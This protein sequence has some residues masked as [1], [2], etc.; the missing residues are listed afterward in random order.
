MRA[1]IAVPTIVCLA[2]NVS[3]SSTGHL[4]GH[5]VLLRADDVLRRPYAAILQNADNTSP[6]ASAPVLTRRVTAVDDAAAVS[7]NGTLDMAAWNAATDAACTKTLSLLPRSSNPSGNCICYNLPSL[8]LETGLFEADLR[9]YRISD[10]RADFA[11]IVPGS[12]KVALQYHGASVT[13][14]SGTELVD[15]MKLIVNGKNQ[16]RRGVMAR[17]DGTATS[18]PRL[19]QTYM[20]VGHV[21]A[22]KLAQNMTI[23]ALEQV[24][25][26]T[27]TLS[28]TTPRGATIQTNLSLNEASFLTGVFSRL[29]I[30]S[31]FSA[32]QAAVSAQREAVRNGTAAFVLPGVQLMVFPIGTV[33]TSAWLALGLAAYAVGTWERVCYADMYWRRVAGAGKRGGG[34]GGGR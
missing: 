31:D 1:C 26:P 21:E 14:V 27:F 17:R 30:Q 15:A 22:E 5:A 4:S 8:D 13:P 20:F 24:L 12:V 16:T 11:G 2:G 34:R 19:V 32:A 29:V 23:A 3:A 33:I 25:L 6:S 10:P 9:L 28:A 7:K 18:S